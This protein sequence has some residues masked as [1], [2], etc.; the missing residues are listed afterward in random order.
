[1]QTII[2]ALEDQIPHGNW[3][4]SGGKEKQCHYF[5]I[6]EP[7]LADNGSIQSYYC[8]LLEEFVYRKESGVNE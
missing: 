7:T 1:M 6:K 8:H 3:C 5:E 4:N 2:E